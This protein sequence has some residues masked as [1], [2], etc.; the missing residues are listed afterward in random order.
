VIREPIVVAPRSGVGS[1]QSGSEP[2]TVAR[3]A[4]MLG[5]VIFNRY[6]VV[7]GVDE[8]GVESIV[9]TISLP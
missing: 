1:T 7:G 4:A 8:N 3:A 2:Q 6:Y 5:P 9:E